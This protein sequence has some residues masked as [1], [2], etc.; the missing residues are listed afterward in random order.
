V[1]SLSFFLPFIAE[2]RRCERGRICEI[3]KVRGLKL[4][5][6]AHERGFEV[7]G[8]IRGQSLSGE[9]VD[10]CA[11]FIAQ[12]LLETFTDESI[13]GREKAAKVSSDRGRS[14][15]QYAAAEPCMGPRLFLRGVVLETSC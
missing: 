11:L 2:C 7:A 1:R 5:A 13:N 12:S 15:D 3:R 10:R 14:R 4:S 8:R 9:D 6:Y